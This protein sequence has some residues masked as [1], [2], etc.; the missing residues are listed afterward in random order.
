MKRFDARLARVERAIHQRVERDDTN[1]RMLLQL[2]AASRCHLEPGLALVRPEDTD[3]ATFTDIQIILAEANWE[4]ERAAALEAANP[5]DEPAR[6]ADLVPPGVRGAE[7][8]ALEMEW[9][10]ANVW[11]CWGA[12]AQRRAAAVAKARARTG[13]RSAR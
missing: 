6:P 8:L 13:N 4:H 7:R 1:H 12:Q 2:I 9:D 11:P 5:P 10:R 3:P